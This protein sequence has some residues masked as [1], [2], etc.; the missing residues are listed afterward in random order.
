MCVYLSRGAMRILFV[1]VLSIMEPC[2]IKSYLL[3]F[4]LLH[5]YKA[6]SV[7]VCSV[8]LQL[9]IIFLEILHLYQ[10]GLFFNVLQ[11]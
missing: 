10:T 6:F 8:C 11:Y 7:C 3:S 4:N 1:P 5:L 2:D 9:L